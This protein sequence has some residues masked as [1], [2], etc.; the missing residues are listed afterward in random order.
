MSAVSLGDL[1]STVGALLLGTLFTAVGFGIT[2]MQTYMYMGR[3]PNDPKLI[4]YTVWTLLCLDIFHVS[5]TWHMIYWYLI[6]NYDN[7]RS[8]DFSVWSFDITVVITAIV[9]VVAHC[10]YARRVYILGNRKWLIPAIILIL[11]AMRLIFGTYVTIRIFQI[12]VL[13]LLWPEIGVEVGVG[14]GSGTAADLLITFTLVWYLRGHKGFNVRTDNL[15][16][17]ITFW[18][19]NN[20]VLT[21]TVGLVVVITMVAMPDNMIYL[22]FHVILSKLYANAL[23]ATLNFRKS[24]HGRGL[25]EEDE[26]IQLSVRHQSDS[27]LEFNRSRR[28]SSRVPPVV[29]VVTTTMTDADFAI[30]S[31][32]K[33]YEEERSVAFEGFKK[34]R[35]S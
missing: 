29:H 28:E 20:G 12:K 33:E 15:V 8:L 32:Q 22:S 1:N 9:T 17:R 7:P 23:L 6:I 25:G 24:Y 5:L 3:F 11:S 26:D 13:A 35:V 34:L 4:H 18:T 14:L 2:T 27:G 16:D 30:A 10:F 31:G 19:V 21:S